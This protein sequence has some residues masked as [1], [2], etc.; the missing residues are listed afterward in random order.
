ME[1]SSH[2]ENN[3][4]EE[5]TEWP[6][7]WQGAAS[8]A[9]E[10][11]L[12]P[13]PLPWDPGDDQLNLFKEVYCLIIFC[14]DIHAYFSWMLTLNKIKEVFRLFVAV[15]FSFPSQ[16]FISFHL[17]P[18]WSI[19]RNDEGHGP[20]SRHIHWKQDCA[21]DSSESPKHPPKWVCLCPHLFLPLC[22]LAPQC[23]QKCQYDY[24][25]LKFSILY[26]LK[27]KCLV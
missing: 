27:R 23:Y 22:S 4:L 18:S 3:F 24:D 5:S 7:S 15:A 6:S 19:T 1:I 14:S 17:D 12:Q 21:G 9:M 26:S 11:T 16:C 20:G 13:S 8:T 25:C 2:P 10:G